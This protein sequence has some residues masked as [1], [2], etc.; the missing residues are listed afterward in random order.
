MEI[1]EMGI[2]IGGKLVSDFRYA[3]DI[4]ICTDRVTRECS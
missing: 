2:K 3:N 1:E 4:A